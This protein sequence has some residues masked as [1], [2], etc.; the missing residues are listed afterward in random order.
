[1]TSHEL[2]RLLLAEE[3]LPVVLYVNGHTHYSNFDKMSHGEMSLKKHHEVRNN[4]KN[5]I[6]TVHD[7]IVIGHGSM[8]KLR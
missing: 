5:G 8:S 6:Q 3:N 2:A 4:I 1:M 7:L